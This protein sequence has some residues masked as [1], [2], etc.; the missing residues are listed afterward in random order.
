MYKLKASMIALACLLMVGCKTNDIEIPPQ[1]ETLIHPE[2]PTSVKPYTFDWKVVVQENQDV[3]IGLSY[4]QSLE[5]R[6]FLE[7]IRR[8]INETNRTLCFYRK[9][10]KEKI[11]EIKR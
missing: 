3:V 5:F 11:C 1:K 6:I 7:D 8:Y 10:L 2:W 9:D 4:D